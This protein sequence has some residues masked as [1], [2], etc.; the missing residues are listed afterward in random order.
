MLL[1]TSCCNYTSDTISIAVITLSIVGFFIL[2]SVPT[3]LAT[4]EEKILSEKPLKQLE[5]RL[6]KPSYRFLFYISD[7][8]TTEK[9]VICSMI[10]LSSLL[11]SLINYFINIFYDGCELLI[12]TLCLVTAATGI[13][14]AILLK[15]AYKAGIG[16][17]KDIETYINRVK[18]LYRK[19]NS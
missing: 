4:R 5:H 7:E 16:E 19:R 3:F 12:F 9:F 17:R 2:F 18:W 8:K 11:L 10:Y 14:F 1:N 15:I 13:L 6:T